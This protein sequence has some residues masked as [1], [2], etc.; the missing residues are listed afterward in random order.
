VFPRAYGSVKNLMEHEHL[1]VAQK[2]FIE[3][4]LLESKINSSHDPTAVAVVVVDP[5]N[6]KDS[7]TE[8]ICNR[9]VVITVTN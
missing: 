2:L 1:I 7:P 6:S 8:Q 9:K 5:F 4:K 3:Q